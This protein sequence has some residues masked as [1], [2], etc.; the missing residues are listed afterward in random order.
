M[1]HQASAHARPRAPVAMKEPR[2][3]TNRISQVTRG[4]D[5][6]VPRVEPLLKMEQA[7]P[8]SVRGNQLNATLAKDGWDAASPRPSINRMAMNWT[9]LRAML[10]AAVNID[11]QPTARVSAMRTPTRS[12][13]QPA[14]SCPKA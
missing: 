2:Q 14:G 11:H 13:N 8:R 7:R 3:P 12:M 4:I 1:N 10:V 6:A 5:S 9:T